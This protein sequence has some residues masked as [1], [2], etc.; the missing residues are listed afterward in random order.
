MVLKCSTNILRNKLQVV[1]LCVVFVGS[2]NT[3]TS[4]HNVCTLEKTTKGFDEL[5]AMY[6]RKSGGVNYTNIVKPDANNI[7]VQSPLCGQAPVDQSEAIVMGKV[8][9]EKSWPWQVYIE[10]YLKS[11]FQSTCGGSIL[12]EWWVL[13]AAHCLVESG[14]TMTVFFGVYDLTRLNSSTHIKA[15]KYIQ[16]SKLLGPG[17]LENDILLVK[18][19]SAI[20]FTEDV[21]PIC[22]PSEEML[23]SRSCFATGF[24]VTGEFGSFSNDLLQ[25]KTNPMN[26]KLCMFFLRNT[27]LKGGVDPYICLDTEEGENICG[28]DSGGPLSCKV[29]GKYYIVGVVIAGFDCDSSMFPSY[30]I[31]V[32]AY[33][34]WIKTSIKSN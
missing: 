31:S 19:E 27:R 10:T 33:L 1:V 3:Q 2:I 28:G 26:Q 22:L 5:Q 8:S 14:S 6:R 4:T 29:N 20:T 15:E 9:P 34:D 24:G 32:Y 16:K 21:R 7:L 18:L 13:T 17:E 12:T 25:I 30:T 23:D 11:G